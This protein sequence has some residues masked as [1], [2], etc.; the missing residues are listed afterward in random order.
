MLFFVVK[1][2][3]QHAPRQ[4]AARTT[5]ARSPKSA[6]SRARPATEF[7][8]LLGTAGDAV[9]VRALQLD[10]RLSR[11]RPRHVA[12]AGAGAQ[13]ARRHGGRAAVA[14]DRARAAPRRA[15]LDRRLDPRR[16]RRRGRGRRPGDQRTSPGEMRAFDASDVLYDARVSPFIKAALDEAGIGG[17]RSVDPQFLRDI[18]WVSP[19]FVASQARQ[20]ALHRH[21]ATETRR[22]TTSRPAP[23]CTAPASTPPPTAASTLSPTASN[24]LT[25]VKGQPFLVAFTNQGDN[26]EFNV[27]VTLKISRAA[28][29]RRSRS[30]RRSRR[31]P[32]ARRRPSSCR[33]TANRRWAPRS[34]INVTVGQG[35]GRREDRQQQG[36]ATRRSSIQG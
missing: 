35:P 6:R 16:A 13:R 33:S 36:D 12:Q 26:D 8:K 15:E 31:S 19:A 14:A 32:R 34:T 1:R 17:Q 28:A 29:A 30:T 24:R 27:K 20:A 21:R 10:P 3:Q 18:S 22:R 11:A 23:A 7:F 25:Y 2:V 4:R 9:A 5:T